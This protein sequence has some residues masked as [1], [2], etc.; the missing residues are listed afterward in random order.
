MTAFFLFL[1]LAFGVF[2]FLCAIV[3]LRELSAEK[4]STLTFD[5]RWHVFKNLGKYRDLTKAKHGRTGPAYYGYLVSFAF[6][7]LAVVLLLDSLVK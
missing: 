5:L 7:L 3:I 4:N 1:V 2:N 6:L